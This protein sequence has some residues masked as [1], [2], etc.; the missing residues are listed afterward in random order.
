VA[1]LM[2]GLSKGMSG[3]AVQIALGTLARELHLAMKRS[4]DGVDF[5]NLHTNA[6]L[7]TDFGITDT[8]ANQLRA[9]FESL[10]VL[11][12]VYRGADPLLAPRNFRAE[13]RRIAGLGF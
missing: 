8:D 6:E 9:A 1:P 7:L 12:K 10:D 5:L 2:A 4:Q 11:W 13:V 3:D